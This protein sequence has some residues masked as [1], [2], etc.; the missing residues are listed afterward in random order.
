MEPYDIKKFSNEKLYF[1]EEPFGALMDKRIKDILL[2]CSK[3]DEFLLEVD[4]RIDEQI[5]Q[6]YVALSIRY[7]P[8]FTQV[9]TQTEAFEALRK[10]KFDLVITMVNLG[11]IMPFELADKIYKEFPGIPIVVLTHFSREVSAFLANKNT[12]HIDYVFSWLGDSSILL[13]IIKL[14]ED[15]MNVEHDVAEVGANCIILVEDSI[16]YYS[17]YLPNMYKIIFHQ[18]RELMSEGL[19]EHQKTMRMRARAKILLANNYEQALELYEKYKE[20]LL[21][22]ISDITY[23]VKGKEYLK[24]GIKLA[25]KIRKENPYMP[26]LLQ[27]SNTDFEPEVKKLNASFLFKHS[28][29]LLLDLRDY[30]KT[31]FG[32][33]EFVFVDPK[34]KR[35]LTTATDLRDLQHK[36]ETI[37]I[38][39]FEYHAV[40]NHFS[41]WFKARALFTLADLIKDK[42]KSDFDN[43]ESVREYMYKTIKNYRIHTSKGTIATFN[44]EF[45]DDY[46]GFS[47]I[48]TGSLGGKARGLA[49]IDSF[50][51]EKKLNYKYD[52]TI[53]N[54]PKTV[55]L[56]TEVF[57]QFMEMNNLYDFALSNVPDEKIL[58]YFV[59]ADLPP[60]LKEDLYCIL[61]Y[62][63]TPLAVRSSSLLEDSYYQPF[64]GVYTTYMIPNNDPNI[65][66][67]HKEL[68]SAIKGVFAST[69]FKFSKDYMKATHNVI[70]EEKMAVIIQEVTGNLYMDEKGDSRFYPTISGVARSLNFYPVGDEKYEHGVV[71]IALGLGKTI[72]DGETSLRF[73][74]KMPKKILQISSA[75]MALKNTQKKFYA[76]DMNKKFSA[77]IDEKE[78]LVH[79]DLDEA[80]KDNSLKLLVSTYDHQSGS[81]TEGPMASGRKVLTFAPILKYD[82]FPL[83]EIIS[84]LLEYGSKEMN[85]PVE[86]E[87]AVELDKPKDRPQIFRFLQIRPIVQGLE[88]SDVEISDKD[89]Q[90]AF[91]SSVHSLGNGKINTLTDIVYIRPETF[92]PS[93]T[94]DIAA[95]LD[96]INSQ[97]LKADRHYILIGPGRWGSSDPWLGIP[98]K[99]AQISQAKVI[100]EHGMKKFHIDP[101]QGS[102][103]FQNITLL[104][105]IYFTINPYLNEG[106]IDFELLDGMESVFENK[107][108]RH[109][110]FESKLKIKVNGMTGNGVVMI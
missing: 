24:A 6:E 42:R 59:R 64:A 34:T 16:R 86:I 97:F 83:T 94:V 32:F 46:S 12:E 91:M 88:F 26:I 79:L 95:M 99:W 51:K 7:P 96:K 17:S 55:V 13:A 56:S 4:G 14:I 11:D 45:F 19:N 53:I 85:S 67:R 52:N 9:S 10:K 100:V 80:Q 40:N 22:I 87:F 25:R 110:R 44:K 106:K 68:S 70:D 89:R 92:D 21:G 33:G 63:R 35:H 105:I 101:S 60:S 39:S 98:V 69:F 5:F 3:Y 65:N 109:V 84:T 8:Q 108:L 104:K 102:H 54:I 71:N 18:T 20:N 76:L 49:F 57:E 107:Y 72:V 90:K 43:M 28:K 36:I 41:K 50:L 30:I 38:D 73:S 93:T 82:M 15:K 31:N 27:S 47:R 29:T 103:F 48:G 77:T 23:T 66:V 78:N 1:K 58:K 81:L 2:I 37:P 74:P 62:I 61:S 75:E